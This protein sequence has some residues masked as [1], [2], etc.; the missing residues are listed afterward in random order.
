MEPGYAPAVC[1]PLHAEQNISP[2]KTPLYKSKNQYNDAEYGKPGRRSQ[3]ARSRSK[4][5]KSPYQQDHNHI[6]KRVK[7]AIANL[8]AK[9]YD[10]RHGGKKGKCWYELCFFR[11]R[12]GTLRLLIFLHDTPPC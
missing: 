3:I 7:K 10:D 11:K 1:R 12:H 2:A 6:L 9:K 4:K 8:T 5:G